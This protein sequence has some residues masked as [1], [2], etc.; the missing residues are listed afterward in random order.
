[1]NLTFVH[2]TARR[3]VTSVVANGLRAGC[4][5]AHAE[6][7]DVQEHL[8]ADL[9]HAG[10]EPVVLV[11]EPTA[12]DVRH[13]AAAMEAIEHPMPAVLAR[14]CCYELQDRWEGCSQTWRDCVELVGVCRHLLPVPARY[15]SLDGQPLVAPTSGGKRRRTART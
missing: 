8:V 2:V 4:Y 13:L 10:H 12:F 14:M 9:I 3:Y 6:D 15:L 1:M 5:F 7:V 11:V